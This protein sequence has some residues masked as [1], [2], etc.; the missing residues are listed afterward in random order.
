[1]FQDEEE[2]AIYSLIE[3]LNCHDEKGAAQDLAFSLHDICDRNGWARAA[4]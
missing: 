4:L 2:K 3:H 1:M